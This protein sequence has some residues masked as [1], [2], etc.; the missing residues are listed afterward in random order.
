[1]GSRP[2]STRRPAIDGKRS[3]KRSMPVTSS[4]QWSTPCSSMR[5]V[6]ARLTW[7]RGSISSTKRSPWTSRMRAPSPRRASLSSGRGWRSIASA[8]GWNWTNSTSA[9]GTPARRA[10]ATPSAVASI[11]LVVTAKS[12]PAPPLASSV[13]RAR[14]SMVV[15][16]GPA[17]RTP[18]QRPPSTSRP[19]TKAPSSTRAAV[20]WT[21][22]TSVRST[23]TPVAT[24]PACTTRAKR[25]PPSRARSSRPCSSRSKTAPRP[26][27]SRT[28]SGPC[29]TS[30]RTASASQ[31]PPPAA[32]VS[33]TWSSVLS[34]PG[35]STA[36]MPPWAQRV[37]A[38]SMPALVTTATVRP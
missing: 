1:M 11:G 19:S 35:S 12:W 33:A 28:A 18:T 3:A 26:M 2:T 8:V 23:S 6:I 34:A 10:M 15:P 14:T 16:P 25:W 5:V 24:P 21:A 27:R 9:T 7:S 38:E 22:S 32:R 30:V 37:V 36:A 4:R 31:R 17:T 13:C 29:P 20:A